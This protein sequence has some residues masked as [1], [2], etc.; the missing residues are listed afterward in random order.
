ML[1]C[2]HKAERR[3]AV[4]KKMKKKEIRSSRLNRKGN[5]L[6]PDPITE[7]ADNSFKFTKLIENGTSHRVSE[8]RT[9]SRIFRAI[10]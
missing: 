3:G 9:L 10:V 5:V 4:G 6:S 8:T 7:T 1:W 2:Q